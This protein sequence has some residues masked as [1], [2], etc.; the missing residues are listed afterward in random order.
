M[1][2]M[3][4]TSFLTLAVISLITALIVYYAIRYRFLDGVDGFFG[5]WIAGWVVA[6]VASPVLGFWFTGVKI[7]TVYIIPAFIGGFIGAFAPAAICKARSKAIRPV[8][9]EV[10]ET[11]RAA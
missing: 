6:W 7:S 1:L 4:F 8:M 3:H 9:F 5:K 2:D 10:H 11:N